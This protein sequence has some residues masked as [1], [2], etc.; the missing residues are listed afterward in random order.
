MRLS[1]YEKGKDWRTTN[2]SIE[3]KRLCQ[4]QMYN[5]GGGGQGRKN[6]M[7]RGMALVVTKRKFPGD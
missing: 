2:Q 5:V 6:Q 4:Q 7:T 1:G 3:K